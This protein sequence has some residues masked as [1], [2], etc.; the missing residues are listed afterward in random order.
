M[1]LTKILAGKSG[2]IL[3]W[4]NHW[5]ICVHSPRTVG[6]HASIFAIWSLSFWDMGDIWDMGDMTGHLLIVISMAKSAEK[7]GISQEISKLFLIITK[8]LNRRVGGGGSRGSIE[9]PLNSLW[10]DRTPF[11]LPSSENHYISNPPILKEKYI[12]HVPTPWNLS[13]KWRFF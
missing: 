4:P 8:H 13:I 6:C 10:S 3:H 12:A 5:L 11:P 2:H 7:M 9:P 1:V